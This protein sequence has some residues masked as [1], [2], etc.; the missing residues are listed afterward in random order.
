MLKRGGYG[1][2]LGF[3]IGLWPKLPPKKSG[4]RRIWIQAVSVGELSSIGKLLDNL[5]ADPAIEVAL[6]GTTSTGLSI[7]EKKYGERLL[8]H[9]PFPLDWLPFSWLAWSRIKPDLTMTIDSELWPEHMR[10]AVRRKVPFMILN[11]R[12]SDRS[13]RRLQLF[14]FLHGILLPPTMRVLASS[15]KQH[16]RWLSLGLDSGRVMVTGNLKIDAVKAIPPDAIAKRR[17]REQFG[18]PEH[19][20]VMA[21][22]STWPGEEKTLLDSLDA[23]RGEKIDARL[24]I[25]PRHAERREE[26]RSLLLASGFPFQL[27]TEH[28]KACP[29]TIVYLADTTGELP[30]LIG[31]ADLAF[32]GK[33]LPPNNGGQNPIEPIA[34]GLP[35]VIGPAY[36]NFR[37]TCSE[38]F[39]HGA[40]FKADGPEQARGLIR[41]LA[42]ND[43]KRTSARQE[44]FAWIGKQ[45]SPTEASLKAI[46][47]VLTR[48]EASK[49]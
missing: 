22:I 25:I 12:L 3:R 46:R 2:K 44:S 21:G 33:T 39:A 19:C 49:T 8:V 45:G 38:L 7:A 34:I 20:F 4:V 32:L 48:G 27:R 5:L 26:I 14:S 16:E 17:I 24:L 35:L 18:F 6:S 11:G 37:E 28:K 43:E 10:Q 15:E 23:L 30:E 41:Q 1:R 29:Q 42:M 36:Q 47:E 40:A 31:A 13:F 9:G